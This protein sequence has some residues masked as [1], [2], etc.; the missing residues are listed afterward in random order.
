MTS[1]FS[2]GSTSAITCVDAD[3]GG[4]R[5]RGRLVVAGEQ[6]RPRPSSR[7]AAI[8]SARGR[9]QRVGDR[10]HAADGAVPARRARRSGPAASA[11]RRAAS[12]CSGQHEAPL[13]HQRRAADLDAVAVDHALDAEPVAVRERLDRRKPAELRREPRARSPARSGARRRPRARPRCGAARRGSCRPRAS[14]STRLILPGRDRAGL[15]EHDRVDPARGLE[16]LGS[17]D[18]QAELRAAA[19]ADEQRGRRGEPERARAGD[20]QHRDGGGEGERRALAGGE[21]ERRASRA[22][23]AITTGTKTPET[24]SAS[25]CTGALPDCASVT[26]RAICASAVSAPTFVARTTSRP[27]ALTVAPTTSSPGCFSTGTDSPVSSD[28]STALAPSSTTPSVATFSPGLTT[29]RSPGRELLDRDAPLGPVV[30]EDGDVLRAELEQR[31]D[32]RRR[33]AAS[34]RLEVAPG[35]DERR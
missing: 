3:L 1:A 6:H 5:A 22:A 34:P 15:V 16:D 2:A 11:R 25:R 9:L 33:R 28:W 21:P 30:V 24:R 26:S 7:S 10:E 18:Q 32:A 17:L 19:R 4:D 35:E 13:G 8:A 23:I 27:P 29:K 12:S 31:G 14:T 20:D